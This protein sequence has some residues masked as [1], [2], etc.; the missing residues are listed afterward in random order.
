MEVDLVGVDFVTF[1][2]H[3]VCILSAELSISHSGTGTLY[4]LPI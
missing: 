2:T 3:W 4:T 1:P